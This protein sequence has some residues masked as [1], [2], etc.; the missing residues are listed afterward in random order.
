M[1]TNPSDFP[2]QHRHYLRRWR[3]VRGLSQEELAAKLK[4]TKSVVSRWENGERGIHMEMQF[5]L[6]DVLRITPA[7]F[8]ADP[9]DEWART[10]ASVRTS[11]LR[12]HIIRE[13]K[14]LKT[15]LKADIAD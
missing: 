4:T 3:E 2:H 6:F 5:R 14:R 13:V 11:L 8:F 9:E 12:E 7:Q 15:S 1:P 10:V